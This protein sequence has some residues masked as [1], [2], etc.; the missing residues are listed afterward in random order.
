MRGVRVREKNHRINLKGLKIS[1][2][3]IFFFKKK[4]IK[5]LV[6][7]DDDM[8]SFPLENSIII[9]TLASSYYGFQ[10]AK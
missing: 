2:I 5:I 1:D 3:Y 7:S 9:R 6:L 10:L 4:Q 8:T